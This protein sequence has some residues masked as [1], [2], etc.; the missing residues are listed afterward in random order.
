MARFARGWRSAAAIL[1]ALIVIHGS[2]AHAAESTPPA[3]SAS[4]YNAQTFLQ[5][6]A[7]LKAAVETDRKSPDAL[8]SLRQSLPAS[9]PVDAGGR[10]FD[11]STG[12]LAS[13]LQRAEK[14]SKSRDRQ[15]DQAREYL[16][17]LAAEMASISGEPLTNEDSART[18]LN[19]ILARPEYAR[20][21]E[22]TWRE[23]LQDRINEVI[24][25]ALTR[26]LNRVGGQRSFGYA[27]LWIGIC[28][29]AILIAFWI[30]RQWMATARGQEMALAAAAAPA[31]SWQEWIFAAR[32]AAERADYRLAIHCAY[33]AAI[34]RLQDLGSLAPD[35]S[36][37]PREY[38]RALT[39]SK[40]LFP[41]TL[42]AKQQALA[43]L[44]SSLEKTWYGYRVA[45]EAD[46]RDSLSQL[47]T[48]G[49]HLP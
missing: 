40:L 38:L 10:H 28:A 4:A 31:Q 18:K 32:D 21:R 43:A 34:V 22:K 29:A 8:S 36:K 39:K 26:I 1:F 33:W 15:L 46:F 24:Y 6:L 41:E 11:V 9:W 23:R 30:F 13:R 27:L 3:T 7:R 49:C 42:S 47:E 17:A 44:T 35:R 2:S 5:E 20:T 37:T 12:Q 25:E 45:T 19:A 48:L 16:D 14:D